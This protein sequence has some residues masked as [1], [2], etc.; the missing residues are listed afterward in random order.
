VIHDQNDVYG[1]AVNIASRIEPLAPPGGICVSE[2][3]YVQIKNKFEFPL[4]TLSEKTLKNVSEPVGVY[5]VILPWE[6]K[7]ESESSLEKT[8]IAVLPFANMS[9]DPADEYFA[10]GLTEELIDRLAQVRE[11][12]VIARTSVMSYKKKLDGNRRATHVTYAH[13][14]KWTPPTPL[15]ILTVKG[16]TH[17]ENEDQILQVAFLG[18]DNHNGPTADEADHR[19]PR[20][21][22]GKCIHWLNDATDNRTRSKSIVNVWVLACSRH[23]RRG[24]LPP[25]LVAI[26]VGVYGVSYHE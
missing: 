6:K 3:V 8:R 10:D 12:E 19:K 5:R 7:S 15:L 14:H 20:R 26:I 1:D 17:P 13:T 22:Q 11:L 24:E 25:I 21:N 9:P 18:G 4:T 23:L 2:Q 16:R